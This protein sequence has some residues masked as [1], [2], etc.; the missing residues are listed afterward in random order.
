MVIYR[1]ISYAPTVIKNFE[2]VYLMTQYTHE[3]IMRGKIYDIQVIK[4]T[5][6]KE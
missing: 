4:V 3:L 1:V 5:T 2:S 6:W